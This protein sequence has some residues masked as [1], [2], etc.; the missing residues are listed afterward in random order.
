MP[1]ASRSA[2]HMHMHTVLHCNAAAIPPVRAGRCPHACTCTRYDMAAL[3]TKGLDVRTNVS[4]QVRRR[5]RSRRR[6]PLTH[7]CASPRHH[8]QL[9]RGL[10]PA[11]GT[12]TPPPARRQFDKSRYTDLLAVLHTITVE[13]LVMAVRRQSQVLTPAAGRAAAAC[14]CCRAAV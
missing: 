14:C 3:K 5:P 7:T 6:W 10:N 1:P 12:R 4:E 9:Q 8:P 2:Q 13:E 11:P